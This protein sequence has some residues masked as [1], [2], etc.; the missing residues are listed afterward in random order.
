[1]GVTN[2][3]MKIFES[4]KQLDS[5]TWQNFKEEQES[6]PEES[7]KYYG[8]DPRPSDNFG[9][10]SLQYISHV[11]NIKIIGNSNIILQE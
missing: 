8:Y 1:M 6:W 4:L 7:P 2:E 3:H 10:D 9:D 11:S 5:F